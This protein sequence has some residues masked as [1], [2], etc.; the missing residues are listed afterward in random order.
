MKLYATLGNLSKVIK[1]LE[2]YQ[3][4]L[5]ERKT[6]FLEEVAKLGVSIGEANFSQ[7]QYDGDMSDCKTYSEWVDDDKIK[8]VF[9]SNA[10]LFIEFGAGVHYT[11]STELHPL[12]DKFGYERGE[13]GHGNGKRDWWLY[14]G[15]G[16][17]ESTSV[18]GMK[19]THGNPA[20]R[21]VYNTAKELREKILDIAKEVFCL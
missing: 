6:R 16:G 1:T 19:I 14:N 11:D 17:T 8:I 4:S 15:E 7:A 13:Y 21:V 10:I 5:E 9:Q 2:R 20:N 18:P 12:A 3:K